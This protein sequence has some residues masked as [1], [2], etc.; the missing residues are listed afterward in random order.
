MVI[1]LRILIKT[2][3]SKVLMISRVVQG[4]NEGKSENQKKLISI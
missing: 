1:S 3:F 4:Q 2:R